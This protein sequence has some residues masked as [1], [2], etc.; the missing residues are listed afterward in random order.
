[1]TLSQSN[2]M[3]DLATELPSTASFEDDVTAVLQ[4]VRSSLA[5]VV[6]ALPEETATG[7]DLHRTLGIDRKLSWKIVKVINAA[8]P[9]AG[10]PHVSGHA[11]NRSDAL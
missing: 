9:L 8:G 6:A 7:A 4:R 3:N 5:E 10:G 11:I 2:L 1:M